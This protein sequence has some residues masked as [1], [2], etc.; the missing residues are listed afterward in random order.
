MKEPSED[1]ER[2]SALLEGRVEGRQR[3]E[4]LAHLS[5][6]DDD[7][8]VFTDTAAVLRALEAEDA[9][10]RRPVPPSMRRRR[11]RAPSLRTAVYA[12]GAA[13]VLLL[14][15]GLVLRGRA[16][17]AARD[18]LQLAM[19]AVPGERGLPAEWTLPAPGGAVR[20]GAGGVA[21]EAWAVYAGALLVDLS[22]AIRAGD[23]GRITLLANRLS[24]PGASPGT[25]LQQIAARPDAPRDTLNALLES[26]TDRLVDDEDRESLELGAWIEAAWLAA[27]AQKAD[28]FRGGTSR[29]MLRRAE[30][31]AADRAAEAAV[32]RVHDTLPR[33]GAARWNVLAG[34]LRSLLSELTR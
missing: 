5:A 18:P 9:R 3:E 8:E 4:L 6:A 33:D 30:A 26:A 20:G 32:E 27:R 31:L 24:D 15:V 19:R 10:A 7:Y 21:D 17:G 25:P 23:T 16:A 22:V 1:D 28:F 2:L 12:A 29:A 13:V 11:W 14:A 34:N